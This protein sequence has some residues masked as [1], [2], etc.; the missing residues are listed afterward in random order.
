MPYKSKENKMYKQL[1]I[2]TLLLLALLS[3]GMMSLICLKSERENQSVVFLYEGDTVNLAHVLLS[4][5]EHTYEEIDH[6]T[7]TMIVIWYENDVKFVAE[8]EGRS[9]KMF[10]EGLINFKRFSELVRVHRVEE[11]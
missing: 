8:T 3:I 7:Q 10:R 1:S 2:F 6:E 9:W 11:L 4:S 5:F